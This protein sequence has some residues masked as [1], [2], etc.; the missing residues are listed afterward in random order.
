MGV[1]RGKN[2]EETKLESPLDK[3]SQR[4]K[5]TLS[6]HLSLGETGKNLQICFFLFV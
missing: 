1:G 4:R 5:K 2:M 3:F 6:S